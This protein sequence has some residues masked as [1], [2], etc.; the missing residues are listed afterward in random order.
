MLIRL[1]VICIVSGKYNWDFH[2]RSFEMFFIFIL[3]GVLEALCF[4][5]T[6]WPTF[7]ENYRLVSLAI[8]LRSIRISYVFLCLFIYNLKSL[9]MN[10]LK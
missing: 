10:L 2:P 6:S 5:S 3:C 8:M 1:V 7:L 4:S 9:S